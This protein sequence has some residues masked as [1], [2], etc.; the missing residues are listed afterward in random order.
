MLLPEQEV[1]PYY[2]AEEALRSNIREGE[3]GVPLSLRLL[4]LDARTCKPLEHAAVDLWHCDGSG[5]YSGYT[6]I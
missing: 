5:I 6:N 2:V 4:L 1:G 3:T